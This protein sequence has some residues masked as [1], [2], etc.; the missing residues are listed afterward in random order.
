MIRARLLMEEKRLRERLLRANPAVTTVLQARLGAAR[1]QLDSAL[2]SLHER[3]EAWSHKKAEWRAKGV[4]KAEAWQAVKAE[5]RAALAQHRLE[6]KT[7]WA[8]WK[9]ARLEAQAALAY[10]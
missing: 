4:A 1:L 5:R 6:L 10:V 3:H 8:E 2:A 9:A 7:A